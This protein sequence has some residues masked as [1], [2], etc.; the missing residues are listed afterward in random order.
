MAAALSRARAACDADVSSEER[1]AHNPD[2]STACGDLST[3]CAAAYSGVLFSKVGRYT[4]G[5]VSRLMIKRF[6]D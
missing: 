5:K 6:L 4:A 2:L 1:K 3:A